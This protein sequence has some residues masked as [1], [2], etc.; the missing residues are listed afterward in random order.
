MRRAD[1][2][3]DA[4]HDRRRA[5]GPAP[6]DVGAARRRTDELLARRGDGDGDALRRG[7][8]ARVP[9]PV[10]AGDGEH[11]G[12]RR[13]GP[14]DGG[15]G[16]AIAR[17]RDDD[18]VVLG[19]VA[20]RVV[21]GGRPAQRVPG[22]RHVDDLRTVV[23]GVLDRL[24][25]LRVGVDGAALERDG[26]R[27]DHRAGRGADHAGVRPRAAAGG[28][29]G[30]ER[31]VLG[32][33]AADRLPALRVADPGEVVAREDGALEIGDGG[34]D[35]GVDDRDDDAL[36]LRLRP[37]L[38]D[39]VLVEPVLGAP[40][41]VR[42]GRERRAEREQQR[43]AAGGG[44]DGDA[45]AAQA[46]SHPSGLQPHAASAR[47]PIGFTPGPAA[48][49]WPM[50]ACRHFTRSGIPPAEIPAISGTSP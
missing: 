47:S 10:D 45:A 4:G 50:S 28:H 37:G 17:R 26:Q 35:P 9:L 21:P 3:D 2:R 12:H 40:D 6:R 36:A 15:A 20:E 19:R 43:G 18:D 38:P 32:V 1:E 24:G 7:V 29:R 14:D 27:Q 8:E 13:G 48:S 39:A 41:R 49:A 30:D 16:A 5:A 44:G 22:E 11:T 25:D 34:V 42:G 33:L 31:P 23:D 46:H